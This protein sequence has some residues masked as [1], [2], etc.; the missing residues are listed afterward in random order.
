VRGIFVTGTSTGIGKTTVACA[1]A[2]VLRSHG[3]EVVALKPFET[4]VEREPKDAV[5]LAR[6]CGR[7]DLAHR[8]EWFRSVL[9]VSPY[10]A[11][12]EGAPPSN[13]DT[14]VGAVRREVGNAIAVVEG[15]GGLLV[16]I[17]A[18]ETIADLAQALVLPLLLVA[19]DHLGVLSDVLAIAEAADRRRLPIAAVALINRALGSDDPSVRTNA[20]ILRERLGSPVIQIGYASHHDELDRIVLE[21]GLLPALGFDLC[22]PK[23]I[24]QGR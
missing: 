18:R 15:A 9:P 2:R 22:G 23:D 12:L 24:P 7:P 6:A 11:I 20:Q 13:L 16:P 21:A 4:G 17:S 1:L 8:P 5:A 14:I 10:A 19:P 3:H